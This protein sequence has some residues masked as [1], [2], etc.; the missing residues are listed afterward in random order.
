MDIDFKYLYNKYYTKYELSKFISM[1]D[2]LKK[3]KVIECNYNEGNWD[4]FGFDYDGIMYDMYDDPEYL[5]LYEKWTLKFKGEI[6]AWI[7]LELKDQGESLE[8]A[9][10][11]KQK[12]TALESLKKE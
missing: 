12:F 2:V 11:K 1:V 8:K 9:L 5:V 7:F 4:R 3:D 10:F 6:L